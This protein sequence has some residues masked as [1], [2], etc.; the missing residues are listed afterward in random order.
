M[1]DFSKVKRVVIKIGT[2]ILKQQKVLISYH[3]SYNCKDE[4]MVTILQG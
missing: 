4:C 2:N 3:T 1:R